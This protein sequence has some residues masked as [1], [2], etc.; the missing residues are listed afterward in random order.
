M[1]SFDLDLNL[2]TFVM[3]GMSVRSYFRGR[4]L[5]LGAGLSMMAREASS[6]SALDDN[7]DK[8]EE[9]VESALDRLLL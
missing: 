6:I 3:V 4:P 8:G 2:A 9:S 7:E 1:R 5:F